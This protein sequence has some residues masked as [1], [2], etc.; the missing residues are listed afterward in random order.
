MHDGGILLSLFRLTGYLVAGSDTP[1]EGHPLNIAYWR[2]ALPAHFDGL[3]DEVAIY[4]RALFADEIWG[5]MHRK[6]V[7][8]D[9]SLVGYWD[10]DEGIGQV[11]YDK[12]GY[13]NDGELKVAGYCD[14]QDP[15]CQ[16]PVWI[17][18]DAPVGICSLEGIVERNLT[19][20]WNAKVSI[21]EQL[22]E[23]MAQ[24]EA[25][26]EYMDEKFKDRD[27]GNASKGNVAKAKQKVMG[28]IQA[29]GQAGTAIDQSLDKL[30]DAINT[31]GIRLND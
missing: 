28:A 20:V 23:A 8:D 26:L 24:E 29:E 31:L 2:S 12:S 1:A 10:L 14:P 27:L 18:S 25:L 5:L 21:L 11:A 17:E 13:G 7:T 9:P 19:D 4:N 30:D 15:M 6:P 16:G 3:I 22:Y